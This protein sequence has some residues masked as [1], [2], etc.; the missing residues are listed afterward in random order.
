M[1]TYRT[2]V[3]IQQEQRRRMLD[4]Q[5]ETR[6]RRMARGT[7]PTSLGGGSTSIARVFRS[8]LESVRRRDRTGSLERWTPP[9]PR[10]AVTTEDDRERPLVGAGAR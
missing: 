8:A 2:V 5:D 7:G 9:G 10:A 1:F 6:L 4:A 3:G